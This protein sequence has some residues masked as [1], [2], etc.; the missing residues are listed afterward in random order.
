MYLPTQAYSS[1]FKKGCS[2]KVSCSLHDKCIFF[3]ILFFCCQRFSVTLAFLKASGNNVYYFKSLFFSYDFWFVCFLHRASLM[4]FNTRCDK[5]AKANH[6]KNISLA[7]YLWYFK[8]KLKLRSFSAGY[9]S[10]IVAF[11]CTILQTREMWDSS[12]HLNS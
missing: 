9:C 12:K 7:K 8:T 1:K 10:D 11:N 3:N 5:G 2:L 4:G 6:I